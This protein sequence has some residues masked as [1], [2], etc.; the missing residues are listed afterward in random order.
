MRAPRRAT[1]NW[2]MP[3][4]SHVFPLGSIIHQ[5]RIALPI[6]HFLGRI[7]PSGTNVS[8][9]GIPSVTYRSLENDLEVLFGFQ[10]KWTLSWMSKSISADFLPND[11]MFLALIHKLQPS[12]YLEAAVSL[13]SFSTG[14]GLTLVFESLIDPNGSRSI[15][16]PED[17]NLS[18]IVYRLLSSFWPI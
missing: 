6:I 8:L 15:F 14:I 18:G 5:R 16:R 17:K 9:T 10:I 13:V 2:E 7:V 11:P 12:I 1:K 3:L 4:S